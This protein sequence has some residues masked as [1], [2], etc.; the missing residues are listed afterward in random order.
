MYKVLLINYSEARGPYSTGLQQ[1]VSRSQ[2]VYSSSCLVLTDMLRVSMALLA[3]PFTANNSASPP[4]DVN[5]FMLI[6]TRQGRSVKDIACN[7]FN[8][9]CMLHGLRETGTF[10]VL[11]S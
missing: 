8:H 11:A 7:Q 5:G 4:G 10:G 2:E 1:Y 6:C 3:L 9:T